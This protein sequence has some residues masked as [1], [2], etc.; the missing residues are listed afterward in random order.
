MKM[1]IIL[2]IPQQSWARLGH[3]DGDLIVIQ[4]QHPGIDTYL[5]S[6]LIDP[7]FTFTVKRDKVRH[8]TKE[9]KRLARMLFL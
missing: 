1:A 8:L 9:E 7:L 5:V 2:E 6:Y 3:K 4:A